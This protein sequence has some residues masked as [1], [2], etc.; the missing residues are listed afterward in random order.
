VVTTSVTAP[1]APASTQV[2]TS[3]ITQSAPTPTTQ[4]QQGTTVVVTQSLPNTNTAAN[5]QTTAIPTTTAPGSAGGSHSSGLSSAGKTAIAVII[6]ILAV[7]ALIFVGILLWRRRARNRAAEEERRKEVEAYG[8]NPNDHGIPPPAIATVAGDDEHLP[9]VAVAGAAGAGYG[10]RGWGGP[11][12]GGVGAR[13]PSSTAV[14]GSPPYP[15]NAM[16]A[17]GAKSP[18]QG[19]HDGTPGHTRNGTMD[20]ETIGV[21]GAQAPLNRGPSNASSTY[22]TGQVSRHSAGDANYP[23]PV[24]PPHHQQDAYYPVAPP[25][26]AVDPYYQQQPGPYQAYNPHQ[27]QQQQQYGGGQPVMRDG[28]GRTLGQIHEAGVQEP[29][30]GISR[31]F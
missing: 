20:S 28:P 13:A 3:V 14:S 21:V 31:N 27:Q 5:G 29:H 26:G 30:D 10:Y 2:L 8:Y 7:G 15:E 24:V 18:S 11:A 4:P 16:Y 23:I 6:P 9:E 22:S 12:T 25:G 1:S 17:G 19:Y